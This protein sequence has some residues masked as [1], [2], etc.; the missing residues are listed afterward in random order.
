MGK[1]CTVCATHVVTSDGKNDAG[2]LRYDLITPAMLEG[3]ARV[4]THGAEEYGS[5]TWQKLPDAKSRYIAA[6]M[7]H[8]HAGWRKGEKLDKKT[9]IPHLYHAAINLLFL[10]ELD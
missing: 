1:D 2:K 9:G 3:L 10:A 8:F 7:R 4:L 5:N 6:E